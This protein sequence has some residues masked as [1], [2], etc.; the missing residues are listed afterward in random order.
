MQHVDFEFAGMVELK[1]EY[2]KLKHL[3]MLNLL[4]C[5][6]YYLIEECFCSYEL[7]IGVSEAKTLTHTTQSQTRK[8]CAHMHTFLLSACDETMTHVNNTKMVDVPKQPQ[9][10][11]HTLTFPKSL[12]PSSSSSGCIVKE[13][14]NH[15][16]SNH[17]SQQLIKKG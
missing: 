13:K 10:C 6:L 12:L 11:Y 16:S 17:Y 14:D 9:Y 5:R 15:S 8:L 3:L 7:N 4:N 1:V 2:G